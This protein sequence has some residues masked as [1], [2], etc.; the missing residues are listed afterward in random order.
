MIIFDINKLML[1]DF[2]FLVIIR[3]AVNIR[4]VEYSML[5]LKIQFQWNNLYRLINSSHSHNSMTLI[6]YQ[7]KKIVLDIG[8]TLY[9]TQ[10]NGYTII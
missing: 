5:W 9:S 3:D 10:V 8:P 1:L 4:L 6:I 7:I 2:I